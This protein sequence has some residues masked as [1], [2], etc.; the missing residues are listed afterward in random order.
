MSR[1]AEVSDEEV[2]DERIKEFVKQNYSTFQESEGYVTLGVVRSPLEEGSSINDIRKESDNAAI[3]VDNVSVS[4]KRIKQLYPGAIVDI[5]VDAELILDERGV[6]YDFY[7]MT[8]CG[9]VFVGDPI[10]L[11]YEHR[12]VELYVVTIIKIPRLTW[13]ERMRQ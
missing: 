8:D 3:N 11:F 5:F 2:S 9:G 13:R 7:R 12:E 6:D 1:C 4:F 10:N